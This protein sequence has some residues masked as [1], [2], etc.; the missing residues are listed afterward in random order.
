MIQISTYLLDFRLGGNFWKCTASYLE[1]KE[2]HFLE[3]ILSPSP[4]TEHHTKWT[5]HCFSIVSVSRYGNCLCNKSIPIL[6]WFLSQ[7]KVLFLAMLLKSAKIIKE[8]PTFWFTV[9]LYEVQTLLSY[10]AYRPWPTDSNPGLSLKRRHQVDAVLC[11]PCP[12]G[13]I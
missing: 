9:G 4:A 3:D 1:C 6:N 11:Y 5:S 10:C 13:N 7:T 12:V 8:F 2:R